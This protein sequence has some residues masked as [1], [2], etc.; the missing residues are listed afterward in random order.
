MEL[1]WA[2]VGWLLGFGLNAVISELPRSH[3]LWSRPRCPS[4][5]QALGPSSFSFLPLGA[6]GQCAACRTS[7]TMLL[8]SLEWPA[9]L[10]FA[11]LAWR[12]G[13][14]WTLLVYSLYALVLLVVFA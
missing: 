14:T 13:A 3:Q 9:A 12:Y 10:A 2:A 6:R 11:L 7:I 1:L 8:R 5:E 4:C